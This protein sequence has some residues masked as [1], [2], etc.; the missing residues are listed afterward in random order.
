MVN[1]RREERKEDNKGMVREGKLQEVKPVT[2]PTERRTA[3]Q[4]HL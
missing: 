1:E 2:L 3:R 4:K